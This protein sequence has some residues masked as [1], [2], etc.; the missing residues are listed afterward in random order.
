MEKEGVYI[1]DCTPHVSMNMVG[2]IQVGKATNLK[3]AKEFADDYPKFISFNKKRISE[4]M[5]KVK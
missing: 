1:Y 5:K 3:K 2:V 4:Y